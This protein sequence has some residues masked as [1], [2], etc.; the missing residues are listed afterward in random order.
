[1]APLRLLVCLSR[2][3]PP[4]RVWDYFLHF[5]YLVCCS[6]E[7][8]TKIYH[9]NFSWTHFKNQEF[10]PKKFQIEDGENS[11]TFQHLRRNPKF[12]IGMPFLRLQ[13]AITSGQ[14]G[15][16]ERQ[17]VVDAAQKE[18]LFRLW[19]WFRFRFWQGFNIQEEH[20]Q[21]MQVQQ[22]SKTRGMIPN[23][24]FEL[25]WNQLNFLK[26]DVQ[27]FPFSWGKCSF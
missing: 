20:R 3:N 12:W 19:F 1:M 13:A 15:V 25:G 17:N 5:C 27:N 2:G 6:H 24:W 22:K 9:W 14:P 8:F 11:W 4:Q 10:P 23:V 26:M 21:H 16:V 7:H 18:F